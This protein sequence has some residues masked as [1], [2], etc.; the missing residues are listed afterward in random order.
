MIRFKIKETALIN[1]GHVLLSLGSHVMMASTQENVHYTLNSGPGVMN[2]SNRVHARI[3][4]FLSGGGWG[5]GDGVE[6]RRP[7]NSL[8]N[9][10]LVI[11]LFYSLQ[12]GS[13]G[14]IKEGRRGSNFFHGVGVSIET[15]ITCD[16]PEG[17]GLDPLIPLWIRTW[18]RLTP[19]FA[20]RIMVYQNLNKT[21]KYHPTTTKRKK[22]YLLLVEIASADPEGG[23]DPLENYKLYGF[24]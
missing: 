17:G 11:N 24:L 14:F 8:D 16:F 13:N 3:Q 21:E 6:A 10:F 1:S 20:Y 22:S 5:W 15:H 18:G 19:L 4:E 7:E 12:S 9:V 23:P 2:K